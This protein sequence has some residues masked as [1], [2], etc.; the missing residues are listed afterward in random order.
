VAVGAAE[1]GVRVVLPGTE[2]AL[3]ALS[4]HSH[5][6]G[7]KVAVGV[8]PPTITAAATDKVATLAEAAEVGI[9]VL[10]AQARGVDNPSDTADLSY[11]V[12]VKPL[13]SEL[14]VDGELRHYEPRRADDHDELTLALAALPDGVGIVQRCVEGRLVTVNGVAWEGEPVAQVHTEGLRTI[15][16]D[17]DLAAKA[18][19]LMRRLQWSGV[20]NLGFTAAEGRRYLIDVNA[21]LYPSLAL[22][23]A[24]GVNLPAIWVDALLGKRA[25]VGG[26][27]VGLK[28]RAPTIL[29]LS[30]PWPALTHLRGLPGRLFPDGVLA[31]SLPT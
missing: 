22:A 15:A 9:D 11:P 25:E 2:G 4:A 23:V 10:P 31:R 16:P 7:P 12:I 20:F 24:A 27:R 19:A 30:D 26:Y 17:A 3:L 5:L 29:S 8:C 13:R 18:A 6:F 28:L 14:P 21:R 1:S